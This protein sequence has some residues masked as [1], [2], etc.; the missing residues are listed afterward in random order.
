M[1]DSMDQLS[2]AEDTRP[3][4]GMLAEAASHLERNADEAE[5]RALLVLK[6]APGQA[7]AL[8]LLVSARRMAGD[9]AG[10]RVKLESLASETPD[11]AAIHYEL[12]LL[13]AEMEEGEA[14]IRAFSRVVELEPKH[15]QAWQGLGD[16]LMQ[17]GDTAGAANAYAQQLASSVVDLKTLEQVS[18]LGHEQLEISESVLREYLDVS[19]TDLGALQMLAR[20]HMRASQYESAEEILAR[21]L[22]IAPSFRSGRHDLVRA[23]QQQ[24]KHDDEIRVLDI[25]L[26]DDPDNPDYRALRASA[27]SASGNAQEAVAACEGMVRAEPGRPEYRLSHARALRGAGRREECVSAFREA[28]RLKPGFGEAWWGLADLK[29][30]R[31]APD[32]LEAMRVQLAAADLS[33]ESRLHLRFALGK[34]LEDLGAYEESFDQYRRGNALVRLENPYDAEAIAENVGREKRQFTR[35][36]FLAHDGQGCLSA[37]PIFIVGVAR[38]GSTLIEH[39]L[40]S[41]S[42]VEGSGELPP[43]TTLVR[44][45]E[46]KHADAARD[47][48]GA[49]GPL[50]GEDFNALGQEY[51]DRCRKYRKQARPHFTD[52]MLSNF[53]H[54]GL[55]CAIFPK[56]RI[57][58]I[59]RHPLACC[60]SNF[61]QIFPYRQGPSYELADMGRYYRGYVELMAHFDR[62]LPDRVHRVIYES[63]VR[64][65]EREIGRLLEYCG[66]PF[67][68]ACLRFYETRRNVLTVS[69]EQV[70]QP[71]YADSIETWRHFEPWLGPL[72]TALGPVLDAWPAAPDGL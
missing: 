35:D 64:D 33:Y 7:Q 62:A 45:L 31:F 48:S 57:I 70:R 3:V 32:D 13:L 71:L 47:E 56:A 14:A 46:A 43:L 34:A 30:F 25:L 36:F 2:A 26:Q 1:V 44:R 53:H 65:P 22:E 69:S 5:R 37:E 60:F 17:A 68:D 61:K 18:A 10:A 40:A 72:K 27:L 50:Q 9:L 66:L 23:L 16:A 58:D 19:P 39:I 8:Q 4:W 52:K 28:I 63:L 38:S 20:L 41:H 6:Y 59:R 54:L 49:P 67:E 29:T 21:A 11:L 42:S 12:G 55:I 15:P 51:L 24:M